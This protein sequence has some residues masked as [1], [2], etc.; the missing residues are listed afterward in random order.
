LELLFDRHIQAYGAYIRDARIFDRAR[1]DVLLR[2]AG[3]AC[4]AFTYDVF[5]RCMRFAVDVD[6][7]RRLW[8]S[9]PVGHCSDGNQLP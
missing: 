5:A 7:G 1:S 4:P 2:Q 9:L 8:E 3:V 6:W